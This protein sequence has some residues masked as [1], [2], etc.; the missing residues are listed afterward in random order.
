MLLHSKTGRLAVV[1]CAASFVPVLSAGGEAPSRAATILITGPAALDVSVAVY[2]AV[3]RLREPRCQEVLDDFRDAKGRP[4]RESLGGSTP[5]GYLERLVI[6]N[7]EKSGHCASGDTAAFTTSGVVVFVCGTTFRRIPPNARA[8]A[9]IHEMLH[10]LG[11][12]ENPPTSTE[13]PRRV[14]ARCGW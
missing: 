11:L 10:T 3:L 8:N 14:Q 9:L 6:R 1:L 2:H 13:I 7:G 12:R 5:E 4:L